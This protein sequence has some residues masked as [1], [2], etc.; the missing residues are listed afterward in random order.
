VGLALEVSSS[1]DNVSPV[2]L[3][4]EGTLAAKKRRFQAVIRLHASPKGP[5][6]RLKMARD[7]FARER[8][9]EVR[10]AAI[11]FIEARW[12]ML[13][14]KQWPNFRRWE[15]QRDEAS[16]MLAKLDSVVATYLELTGPTTPESAFARKKKR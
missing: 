12:Q 13:H 5:H 8:S 14:M 11:A 1:I 15:R 16:L 10:D 7:W 2:P 4:T 6:E 3:T 9:I